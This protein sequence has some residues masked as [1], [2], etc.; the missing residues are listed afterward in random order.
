MREPGGQA[1]VHLIITGQKLPVFDIFIYTQGR[2]HTPK[3]ITF[4]VKWPT[5]FYLEYKKIS[6][7]QWTTPAYKAWVSR[8]VNLMLWLRS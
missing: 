3:I 7:F 2:P 6:V 4:E 8:V 5:Y 1:F